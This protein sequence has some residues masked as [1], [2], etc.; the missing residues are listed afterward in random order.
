MC[1]ACLV[2]RAR[3]VCGACILCRAYV[4]CGAGR[5]YCNIV[6]VWSKALGSRTRGEPKSK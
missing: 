6:T 2:C 1:G 4:V 3:V 5:K